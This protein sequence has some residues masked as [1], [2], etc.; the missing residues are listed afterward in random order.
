MSLPYL[1]GQFVWCRFPNRE[2]PDRPGPKSRVG[3][4]YAVTP[5]GQGAA[6]MLYT[7]TVPWSDPNLP[8]GV[9]PVDSRHAATLGQKPFTIDART[10]A[11]LPVTAEYFPHLAHADHG[12]RGQAPIQLVRRIEAAL[13]DLRDR[14]VVVEVRGPKRT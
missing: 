9:I 2:Q 11:V 6:A 4:V 12:I 13:K 5:S 14:G 7:T 10:A 1:A 8:L 3:Y